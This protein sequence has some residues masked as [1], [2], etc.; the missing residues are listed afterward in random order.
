MT[1]R[2]EAVIE[3]NRYVTKNKLNYEMLMVLEW[4][5]QCVNFPHDSISK[6]T[7]IQKFQNKEVSYEAFSDR[8]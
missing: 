3:V 1:A 5:S 4:V 6:K 7:I 8:F 2:C